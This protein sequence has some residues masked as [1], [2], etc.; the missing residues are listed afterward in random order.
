LAIHSVLVARRLQ[1]P[2]GVGRTAC[3]YDDVGGNLDLAVVLDDDPVTAVPESA[4]PR[5]ASVRRALG[6]PPERVTSA[7]D[8]RARG[9]GS[10]R[11]SHSGCTC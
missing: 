8:W 7:S 11:T 1:Q 9:T 5:A 6:L 2:G 4:Q 3:D 10:R